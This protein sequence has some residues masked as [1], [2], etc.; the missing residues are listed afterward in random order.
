M[1]KIKT[2]PDHEDFDWDLYSGRTKE[3]LRVKKTRGDNSKVYCKE[4][5]AQELYDILNESSTKHIEAPEIGQNLPGVITKVIG[6]YAEVDINWRESAYLDL[7]KEDASYVKYLQEGFPVEVSIKNIGDVR[8]FNI[9][10]SY[11]DNIKKQ[12]FNEIKDSIGKPVAFIAKVVELIHGGYFLNIDGIRVFMPG[13]LGGMN[14]LVDFESLLGQEIYVMPITYSVEKDYIAVSH[15][16]YLKTLVSSEM[17]KLEVGQEF[18]G[19]VTGTTKF[20]V[21]VEFNKCLTGMIHKSDLSDSMV[22]DFDNGHIRPGMSISGKIKERRDNRVVL[23]Q[24]EIE[25]SAT[26]WD[27]IEDRYSVPSTVTGKVKRIVKYGIF[28]ELEPKL[29]GLLHK[30][31]IEEDFE[32]E[33]GQ[34]LDVE[35]YKIDKETK[36]LFFKI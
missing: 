6:Q 22:D 1:L 7:K 35:L 30:S 10:A 11:T 3:N 4:P 25:V 15:R 21:F 34:E 27:D 29:V 16:K 24:N 36:K 31:N 8:G 17:D 26:P 12:K 5:Y 20:G 28:V 9:L 33:V 18:D 14:K 2:V 32:F 13:S 23:T 19:F